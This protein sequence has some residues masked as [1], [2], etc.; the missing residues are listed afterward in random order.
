MVSISTMHF[1]R[2][3]KYRRRA[4]LVVANSFHSL[5]VPVFGIVI[6]LL[7]VRLNSVELWGAFVDVMIWVQLAA[8]VVGWGNKEFLLRA[9]SRQPAQMAARWQSNLVTRSALLL[10]A[11]L[12]L[13]L[14]G[15]PGARWPLALVWLL[16]LV[17]AQAHDAAI[18]YRRRF[19]PAAGVELAATALTV[20]GILAS[21][22]GLGVDVLVAIFALAAAVRALALSLLFRGDVWSGFGL[23][24]ATLAR[25]WQPSQLRLAFSF[26]VLGLTGM[27]HS[28]VDLYS[29]NYFLSPTEV[30]A[31]QVFSSFL[32][33]IQALSAFLLTPFLKGVFRLGY[34]AIARVAARLFGFGL[35]IIGPALGLIYIILTFL[36]HLPLPASFYLLGAFYTLPIFYFLPTI[37]ALY[38]AERQHFVLAVNLGGLAAKLALNIVL[39]PRL[40][41]IGAILSATL[42]HW[43]VLFCYLFLGRK[44]RAADAPLVS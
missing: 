7:V 39:L 27:L 23:H 18:V 34:D 13:A 10:A 30:G 1:L 29:V 40:G 16:A 21:G 5:L 35:I 33:T 26:F 14:L 36:Y 15:W 44:L 12:G 32:L 24:P 41:L 42:V 25:L 37:Y 22:P 20:G 31:Y 9:F 19:V 17:I 8:M 11:G 2:R 43:G 3:R 4:A 28:R 38:K 6:S